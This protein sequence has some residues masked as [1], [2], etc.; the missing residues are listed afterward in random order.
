[1]NLKH[2]NVLV[3]I[4]SLLFGLFSGAFLIMFIMRYRLF[5]NE[6]KTIDFSKEEKPVSMNILKIYQRAKVAHIKTH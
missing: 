6:T 4:A 5:V 2:L 3:P 1:M